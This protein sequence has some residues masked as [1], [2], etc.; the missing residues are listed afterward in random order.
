[1]K[2]L[3]IVENEYSLEKHIDKIAYFCSEP[4][5]G[6]YDAINKGISRSNGDIIGIINSVFIIIKKQKTGMVVTF[7][8]M[9]V[10]MV[11][12]YVG[13]LYFEIRGVAIAS[14]VGSIF[15]VALFI[16]VFFHL[17]NRSL[18]IKPEA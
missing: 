17:S 14:V 2:S 12:I 3:E 4:D 9:V 5:K 18:Q 10:N 6:I 11:L 8:I 16:I 7:L 15:Q 1:M 13:A